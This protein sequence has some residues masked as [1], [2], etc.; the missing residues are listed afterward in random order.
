VNLGK[1]SALEHED[2][3]NLFVIKEAEQAQFKKG[4]YIRIKKGV[5]E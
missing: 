4:D 1:I 5:Y 3:T 2:Y